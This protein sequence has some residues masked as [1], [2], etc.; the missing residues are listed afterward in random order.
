MRRLLRSR[1]ARRYAAGGTIGFMA[2][3]APVVL[4]L[5][6]GP[7]ATPRAFVGSAGPYLGSPSSG[8]ASASAS[9]LAAPSASPKLAPH[10]NGR[11]AKATVKRA[12][13][14]VSGSNTAAVCGTWSLIQAS[15]SSQLTSNATLDAS[16]TTPGLK[17][18]SVRVPWTAIAANLDVVTAGYNLA[19]SHGI[20]YAIR[21]MAGT[22]TPT[23]DLG[24]AVPYAGGGMLP[25]PWGP[26]T[27]P[28]HFVPN[29]VF[30][31]A[32]T[33]TVAELA[34]FAR[35]HG[36]RELHLPWYGYQ[37][38]L[39]GQERLIQIGMRYA[40]SDLAVEFPFTG[41]GTGQVDGDLASFIT[42]TYGAWNPDIIE[43]S[44]NLTDS[45]GSSGGGWSIYNGRQMVGMGD[46]NWSNV[47]QTLTAGQ[48]LSVE[49][50]DSSFDPSLAHAA[51]LRSEIASFSSGVVT[52]EVSSVSP[53]AG[54][55][56]GGQ[57]VTVLG[58]AFAPGMSVT[59]G[60]TAVTPASVTSD[61]FTFTT[62][63]MSPGY[64]Q[65]QVTTSLGTSPLTSSTG[66]TF[67]PLANYVPLQPFRILDTR[68][69]SCV[70]CTGRPFSTGTIWKLQ[71]TGVTGLTVGV[72][73]IPT[74]ATAVV[75]NVAALAGT[76]NSLLTVY[77]YGTQR[78]TASNLN[79]GRGKVIPNLVTAAVGE[80]GAVNIYNAEGTVNVIAD[81]E[82]YFVP[83]AS[84]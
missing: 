43:Q 21:F 72:D 60:G 62:P 46:Y 7:P 31:S 6:F 50:Y 5:R 25:L 66:Y 26:G 42:S 22:S 67:V 65:I 18:L 37:N 45:G 80:G 74:T 16:L 58:N 1:N 68:T 64:T 57:T 15:S 56:D 71:L 47:Y 39:T 75:L 17:G 9:V 34:A 54:P 10:S 77:P 3:A 55:V 12:H 52:P 83:E 38:F 48:S 51:L 82:G 76:A 8:P 44:N 73:P 23:Q 19:Q 49:I 61:S 27:T 78:P 13:A 84:S 40:G 79:F 30:E 70:Q 81:V 11:S 59:V 24:N 63:A 4:L 14:I 69:T 33:A 32:Y 36:V 28:T 35:A 53:S 41:I 2:L 20:S 29:T